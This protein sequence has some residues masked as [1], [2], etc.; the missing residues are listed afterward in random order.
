V[1]RRLDAAGLLAP[2]GHCGTERVWTTGPPDD[3]RDVVS[4][5]W[6]APIDV[7]LLN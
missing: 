2:D 6:G 3:T 7:T 4:A 1:R 5:L